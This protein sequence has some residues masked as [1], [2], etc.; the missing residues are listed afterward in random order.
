MSYHLVCQLKDN[1]KVQGDI[2]GSDTLRHHYKATQ[3]AES[4]YKL[5]PPDW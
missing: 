2:K 4:M 1:S 3:A 5:K